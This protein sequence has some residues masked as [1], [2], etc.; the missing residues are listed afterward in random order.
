VR[1][2]PK[3]LGFVKIPWVASEA[4][5]GVS[6]HPPCGLACAPDEYVVAT[7]LPIVSLVSNCI[8]VE[9]SMCQTLS[10]SAN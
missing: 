10:S 5:W 8:N 7:T 1:S 2:Y 9:Q 4:S 3:C 6:S